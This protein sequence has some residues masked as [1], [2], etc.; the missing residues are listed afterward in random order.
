MDEQ[1]SA[2]LINFMILS[3][4]SWGGGWWSS[5]RI[6]ILCSRMDRHVIISCSVYCIVHAAVIGYCYRKYDDGV[7]CFK[8]R[9]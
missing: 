3:G 9:G 5:S 6:Y 1:K 7:S 2:N 4:V 8:V